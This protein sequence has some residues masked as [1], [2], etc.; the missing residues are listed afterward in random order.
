M[1]RGSLFIV[2]ALTVN[3]YMV[4]ICLLECEV[5]FKCIIPFDQNENL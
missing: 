5:F 1:D 4:F 3:K 2:A